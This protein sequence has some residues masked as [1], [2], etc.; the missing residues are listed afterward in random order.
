VCVCV[1]TNTQCLDKNKL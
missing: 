1:H